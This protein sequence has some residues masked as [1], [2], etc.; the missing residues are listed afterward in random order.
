L[1]IAVGATPFI[2][3]IPSIDKEHVIAPNTTVE[4]VKKLTEAA[5]IIKGELKIMVMPRERNIMKN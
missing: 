3:N 1:I 5:L 4:E 2:P